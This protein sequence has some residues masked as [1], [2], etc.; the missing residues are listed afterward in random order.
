LRR[1]QGKV[2]RVIDYIGN[3]RIFLTKLRALLTV[4]P[5]DRS[6]ALKLDQIIDGTLPL[7]TGWT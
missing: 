7:P 1:I 2:L 4:G 6:L 5:G 3:H